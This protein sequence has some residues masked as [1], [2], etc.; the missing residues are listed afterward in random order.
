MNHF[1]PDMGSAWAYSMASVILVGLISLISAAGLLLSVSKLRGFLFVAVSFAAGALYGDAF[2]HLIPESFER[3][4]NKTIPAL[5][6]VAGIFVF[7]IFEKFLHWHHSHG[8]DVESAI[9]PYGYLNLFAD[10]VHNFM[11][12]LLI[13]ASYSISIP[14]GMTTTVA[15]VLHEI[16][17]EIGDIGILIHAGFSRRRALVFNFLTALVAILGAVT[18]LML[19]ELVESFAAAVLPMTAGGF[20]YISGSDLMPE[21]Q[22]ETRIWKSVVQIGAM[23][24]GVGLMLLFDQH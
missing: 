3:Y 19:G 21:F 2:I 6:V 18:A 24:A 22:K 4:A 17:Q 11:D 9:E 15:V 7:F 12:G 13:G 1:P 16:P 5:Y 10:G 8:V 23:I 14:I 20:I